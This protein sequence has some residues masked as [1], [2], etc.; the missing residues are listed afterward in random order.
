MANTDSGLIQQIAAALDKR[1]GATLIGQWILLAVLTVSGSVVLK[2][3]GAPAALL[4]GPLAV[5]M[6]FGLCGARTRLPVAVRASG[7]AVI[8]CIIAVAIGGSVGPALLTSLP[9]LAASSGAILALSM[10]LAATL[11]WARWFDGP[12]AVWGLAPGGA[13]AMVSLAEDFGANAQVTALMQYIRILFAAASAILV[14]HFVAP[15]APAHVDVDWFP[16]VSLRGIV[17]TLVLAAA[18][19]LAAR[20]TGFRPAIF[21]LPG[22]GGAALFAA[23]WVDPALPPTLVL[24]AYA[25]VGLSIGLSFTRPTLAACFRQLHRIAASVVM[26]LALCAAVGVVMSVGFGVDPL[27]AY[28]S[29][30]PGGIDAVLIVAS[31][32]HLDLSFVL[33]AQMSRLLLTLVA[34]PAITGFMA[35]ALKSRQPAE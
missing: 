21:L 34:G 30:S 26:L 1:P 2:Q 14:S 4:L 5:G 25:V 28:L 24:P 10:G 19:F 3:I 35:R 29:T 22:L 8:G 27:T 16:A 15:A 33:A 32:H 17:D 31:S 9:I 11:T 7:Q 6:I 23:G 13:A 18:G 12:T 20:L